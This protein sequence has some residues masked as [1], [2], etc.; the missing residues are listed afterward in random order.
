MTGFRQWATSRRRFLA[1]TL[2][3]GLLTEARGALGAVIAPRRQPALDPLRSLPAFLDTLLPADGES[4]AAT[5]LAV[6]RKVLAAL[7][8]RPYRR[9]LVQGCLWLDREARRRGGTDFAGLGQDARDVIVAFADS[10]RAGSPP[11]AFFETVRRAAFTAYY[12]D[13]RS[14]PDIGYD[15]PP[16]PAGFPDH[17][18]PPPSRR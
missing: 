7:A 18:S 3:G 2:L 16:Q 14:W 11:R 17:A 4:P 5:A 12:A 9:L 6:D 8:G 15:G 1:A 10:R 13:A